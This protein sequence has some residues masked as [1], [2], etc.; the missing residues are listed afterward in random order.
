L[1]K[2]GFALKITCPNLN[3]GRMFEP[4]FCTDMYESKGIYGENADNP[5]ITEEQFCT[6]PYCKQIVYRSELSDE[7]ELR[8]STLDNRREHP[9][10][11]EDQDTSIFE[12]S[13]E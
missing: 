5:I 1:N 4:D 11:F 13:D 6:C 10:L 12:E 3:C 9:E 7:D 8:L 2:Q